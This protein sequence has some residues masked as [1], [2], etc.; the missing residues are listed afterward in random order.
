M[1]ILFRDVQS[2]ITSAME[3]AFIGV[4]DMEIECV[5]IFYGDVE[6]DAIISPANCIGRMDGG[7]DA[8]YVQYFGWQLQARLCKHLIDYY[9]G[10]DDIGRFTGS[11]GRVEIGEATMIMTGHKKIK[12]LIMAP[13]M[14]WPPGRIISSNNAFLAFSAALK[15]SNRLGLKKIITPG[16]GTLTGMIPPNIFAKQMRMAWDER[17]FDD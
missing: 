16:L 14:D 7:I 5:N 15:L 1:K 13:T 2:E 9:G 8:L 6:A 10:R 12:A 11:S 3:A 4:E 17:V